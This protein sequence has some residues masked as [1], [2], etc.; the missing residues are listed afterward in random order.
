MSVVNFKCF[1]DMLLQQAINLSLN[2]LWLEYNANFLYQEVVLYYE[3]KDKEIA[4]TITDTVC[5][6]SNT[7]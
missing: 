4:I 2:L 7:D 1:Y 6:M 3:D 5:I